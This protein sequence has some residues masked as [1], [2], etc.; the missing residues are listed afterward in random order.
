MR[1]ADCH[2]ADR[3]N[4]NDYTSPLQEPGKRNYALL[5]HR[6]TISFTSKNTDDRK[7]KNH[8]V[9]LFYLC[10]QAAAKMVKR[11]FEQKAGLG[12]QVVIGQGFGFEITYDLNS[13]LL[14]Y[15]GGNTGVLIW[16]CA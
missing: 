4:I 14:L 15:V 12:W 10:V 3:C 1:E 5:T 11:Q 6:G 16:K 2:F 7:F 9:Y 13:V 8:C